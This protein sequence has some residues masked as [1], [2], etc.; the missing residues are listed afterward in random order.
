MAN[1]VM[2]PDGF[3][4][5]YPGGLGDSPSAPA[6]S[7]S[8]SDRTATITFDGDA[9]VTNY[10]F[11]KAAGD[12]AW[13]VVGN[14]SGDGDI[15]KSDLSAGVRYTF[16]GYS[17]NATG[18]NSGPS[19]T[20]DVLI[21]VSTTSVLDGLLPDQAD[22]VLDAFGEAVTYYPKGG[23]SRDIVAVVDRNPVAGINGVPH[24]NT[25]KFIVLVK[26]DGSDGI[27]SSEVNNGGDHISFATRIGVTATQ[28]RITA[29]QW[30]DV[31]MMYL[32]VA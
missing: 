30:H 10:L 22:D 12:S 28:K 29:I 7:V 1:E 20:L 13:T 9:G 11:C 3:F 25:S 27:S 2:F 18:G 17:W 6:I 21:Q 16:V 8:V 32:E 4:G 14:R 24:G 15:S 26:N 5:D 19:I 31:G 23:S